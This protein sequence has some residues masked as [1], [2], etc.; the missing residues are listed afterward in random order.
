[1]DNEELRA[2]ATKRLKAKADFK[3]YVGIWIAITVLLVAIWFLTSP[4]SYFWPIWPIFAMGVAAL[5]VGLDA[6]GPSKHISDNAIDAEM[7][8][9]A[10]GG[11]PVA[12]PPAPA[13]PQA[14]AAYPPAASWT[15]PA[16]SAPP[17]PPL[18]DAS[19]PT[20]PPAATADEP[21]TTSS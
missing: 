4:G 12:A 10:G 18:P 21:G 17:V 9:L 11:R 3:N 6:Y 19:A 8:R 2:L 13:S 5:F 15:D 14:T 20:A 16:P 1:M 7:A